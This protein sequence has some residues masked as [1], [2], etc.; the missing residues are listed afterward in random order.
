M[1]RD[2]RIDT[3]EGTLGRTPDFPKVL[4]KLLVVLRPRPK[5]LLYLQK[6]DVEGECGLGALILPPAGHFSF[7]R[8]SFP[9]L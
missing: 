5:G 9:Y 4:Q 3:W 8:L 6:V 2:W 7:L 1:G